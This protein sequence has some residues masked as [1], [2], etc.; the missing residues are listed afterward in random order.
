MPRVMIMGRLYD[1]MVANPQTKPLQAKAPIKP[2][3]DLVG[4]PTSDL[5]NALDTCVKVVH[6]KKI[7]H[8]DGSSRHGVYAD[9]EKRKEYRREWMRSKRGEGN[10]L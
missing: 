10:E 8:N 1:D 9:K 6:A 4:T 2:K 7:V 5:R 3:N